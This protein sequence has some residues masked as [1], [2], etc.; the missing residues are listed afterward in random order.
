MVHHCQGMALIPGYSRLTISNALK[1]NPRKHPPKS[2]V[3]ISY[4]LGAARPVQMS[5]YC[6]IQIEII[7]YIAPLMKRQMIVQEAFQDLWKYLKRLN[8]CVS[9]LYKRLMRYFNNFFL[10]LHITQGYYFSFFIILTI[11]FLYTAKKHYTVCISCHATSWPPR[12]LQML[13]EGIWNKYKHV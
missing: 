6:E 3:S 4:S 5:C 10:P 8:K 12:V 13:F 7:W 1:K 11:S 2:R 9:S